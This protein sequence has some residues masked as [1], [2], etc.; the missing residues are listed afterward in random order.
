MRR[1]K[2]VRATWQKTGSF[3]RVQ[4]WETSILI[5]EK[6]RAYASQKVR[7]LIKVKLEQTLIIS[8]TMVHKIA[9]RYTSRK[10]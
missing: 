9:T 3:L 10:D 8:T 5:I 7:S 2:M 4:K 6:L 1:M